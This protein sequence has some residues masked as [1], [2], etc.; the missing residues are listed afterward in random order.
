MIKGNIFFKENN[1]DKILDIFRPEQDS[2]NTER[3]SYN[4]EIVDNGVQFNLTARDEVGYKIVDSSIKKLLKV[5]DKIKQL[6][7]K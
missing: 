5:Y 6:E 2:L 3:F 7:S 1:P 4:I